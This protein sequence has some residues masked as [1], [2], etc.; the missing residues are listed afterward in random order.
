MARLRLRRN[1]EGNGFTCPK[2]G[3][4]SYAG[5]FWV[6]IL[7]GKDEVLCPE[8]YRNRVVNVGFDRRGHVTT[9][10]PVSEKLPV[11]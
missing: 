11:S 5:R 2:C 1:W 8:C 7:D 9:A 6:L 10:G 4:R 3:C